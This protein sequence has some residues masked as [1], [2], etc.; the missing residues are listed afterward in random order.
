MAR[1]DWLHA[2]TPLKSVAN[3][4]LLIALVW[5]IFQIYVAY[6][7]VMN[8]LVAVPVHVMFAVA[9]ALI[10]KPFAPNATGRRRI[11]LRAMDYFL[12][13][14]AAVVAIYFLVNSE[15][16]TTRIAGFDPVSPGAYIVGVIALVLVVE[17]TRRIIGMGLTAVILGFLVYQ[18]T[19]TLLN[20]IPI[21]RVL[22]HS[23]ELSWNFFTSFIDLQILQ[24]QGVFGIPSVVSYSQV[25]YFLIFGAFLETFGAGKLFVDVATLLVG[26]YRGGMA[27]V[28][29]IASTLFGAVSGS[30]TANASVMG[31]FTIPAMKRAGMSAEEAAAVEATASSGGQIMPPVMGAAAF[32]IAQFLGKP[33]REIAIA[34]LIPALLF[35]VALFCVI[36]A[37]AKKK[38][39]RGL[40][41]SEINVT[42]GQLVR[43]L[44]L[45]IPVV[46][47]VYEILVGRSL[48]SAT[49]ESTALTVILAIVDRGV[50]GA[51]KGGPRQV[52]ISTVK[53]ICESVAAMAAG[54]RA[55]IT[56]AIPCAGA[57]IVVGIAT[58]TNLGL[59]FGQF[60]AILAGGM[61]IPALLLIMVVVIIM[62]MGMPTTAA[63]IM[64]AILA[65]PALTQFHV[66]LISAHF[67]VL[68]FAVL[69]MVTPPVA[70]AAFVAGGIAH[71]DIW[72][73]GWYAFRN[74]FAGFLVA[75][76]MV[77]SPALLLEGPLWK[78]ALAT[79]TAIIGCYALAAGTVGY[80]RNA[81]RIWESVV[82]C[83]A[84]VLLIAPFFIASMVGLLML[85]AVWMWQAWRSRESLSLATRSTTFLGENHES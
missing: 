42:W 68:Y 52:G 78:T 30:A 63:Y 34:G 33:Y 9:I 75:F 70:L 74:S 38:G 27:K 69:S 72:K 44:Y 81:N 65:I 13:V 61:L 48:S 35:Y 2:L 8:Y 31:T 49:L 47:L 83:I 32:L 60:V 40:K 1:S 20:G 56:V 6:G 46:W 67:F 62:G 79:I 71:A 11:A 77:A 23:G 10:V 3:P 14:C 53:V 45:F 82:L 37:T 55:A 43:E 85:I 66:P 54:S 18:F 5:A 24:N 84:A 4:A 51:V 64:G 50:R 41:R 25:Y 26:R 7:T 17:A 15:W 28:A 57:G 58:M 19:G 21:L 59:T 36:D 22:A 12:V 16:I 73:T 80:L 76:A 29:V 39:Y